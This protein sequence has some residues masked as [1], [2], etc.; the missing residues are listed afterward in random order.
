V[1]EEFNLKRVALPEGVSVGKVDP[2]PISAKDVSLASK[3]HGHGVAL[4]RSDL[5]CFC[6]RPCYAERTLASR[7]VYAKRPIAGSM[8]IAREIAK[9]KGDFRRAIDRKVTGV[10]CDLGK[11]RSDMRAVFS[12]VFVSHGESA[13]ELSVIREFLRNSF[14]KMFSGKDYDL[15]YDQCDRILEHGGAMVL[16]GAINSLLLAA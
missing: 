8:A 11:F 15:V 4:S 13:R 6:G 12:P 5:T 2:L 16:F 3:F 10:S 14:S 7:T 9:F 1:S